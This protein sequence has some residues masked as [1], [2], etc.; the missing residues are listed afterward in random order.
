M[1]FTTDWFREQ[2]EYLVYEANMGCILVS[3]RGGNYWDLLEGRGADSKE[4]WIE[5]KEVFNQPL[6]RTKE[7]LEYYLKDILKE[8]IND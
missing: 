2:G 5:A 7:P 8:N 6:Y 3:Y 1:L 4:N